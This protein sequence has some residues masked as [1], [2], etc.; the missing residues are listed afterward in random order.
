[1]A[2]RVIVGFPDRQARGSRRSERRIGIEPEEEPI[3]E[4][5]IARET[6]DELR[7]RRGGPSRSRAVPFEQ[8]DATFVVS[9]RVLGEAPPEQ[10]T[11]ARVGEGDEATEKSRER[12]QMF[13]VCLRACGDETS[14]RP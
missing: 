13:A 1:M 3:D 14:E 4:P 8:V 10:V 7:E 11:P 2:A 5:P 9:G 6:V 12:R